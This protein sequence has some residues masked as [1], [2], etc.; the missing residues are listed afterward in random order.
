MPRRC[1]W[2]ATANAGRYG[3]WRGGKRRD[4]AGVRATPEGLL[5]SLSATMAERI[6]QWDR[7]GGFAAIRNDWLERAARLGKPIRVRIADGELTGRFEGID[8]SGR[9]ILRDERG[10][11]RAIAAGDVFWAAR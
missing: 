3:S 4:A 9:L 11:M 7:G 1:G 8:G 2:R 5:A 10:A 6:V